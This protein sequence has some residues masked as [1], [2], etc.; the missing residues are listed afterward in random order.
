[1]ATRRR[2]AH[3]RTSAADLPPSCDAALRDTQVCAALGISRRSLCSMVACGDFPASD[4]RV[5]KRR[6][7]HVDTVNSWLRDRREV[8]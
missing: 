5:G 2:A 7:W 3:D 1:M 4:L 6:R 8:R